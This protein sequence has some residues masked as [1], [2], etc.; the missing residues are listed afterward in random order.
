MTV[1]PST[2]FHSAQSIVIVIDIQEKLLTAIPT[3]ASLVKNAAFLIDAAKLCD[4]PILATEQYPKGL[5]P[6]TP[7]I[8]A[9]LPYPPLAKTAFSSCGAAGFLADLRALS[10]SQIVLTGMEAHVCIMQTG[11]DL[12][13]AGY[14]VALP[15]DALASR[16]ELDHRVGLERLA[17]A[18]AVLTTVEAI[19]FEWIADA[20]HPRFKDYSRLVI[21]R[22]S[23][24]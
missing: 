16:S 14:E 11:L 6:T 8:A 18:G 7:E 4:V 22:S 10:R 12:L 21:N 23:A 20:Q 3:A 24:P 9:R 5:G 1:M 13:D 17:H 19:G 15:V 2:R